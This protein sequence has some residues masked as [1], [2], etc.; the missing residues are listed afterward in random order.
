MDSNLESK[1]RQI[2][3]TFT[4]TLPPFA[5]EGLAIFLF[6]NIA[7]DKESAIP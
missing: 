2:E 4:L 1:D 7:L 3:M 5:C 6:L